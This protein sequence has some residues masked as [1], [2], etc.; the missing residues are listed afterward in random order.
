MWLAVGL[1][2]FSIAFQAPPGELQH[3]LLP[4]DVLHAQLVPVRDVVLAIASPSDRAA[5]VVQRQA[6]RVT[7]RVGRAGAGAADGDAG[8]A[9]HVGHDR[10]GGVLR[11]GLHGAGAVADL[12]DDARGDRRG[13]QRRRAAAAASAACGLRGGC[14]GLR[15]RS[16]GR[17]GG[18][19]PRPPRPRPWPAAAA[20][21]SAW[22]CD[23]A[24]AACS[25]SRSDRLAASWL[26]QLRLLHRPARRCRSR[27]CRG[28]RRRA[29]D[30]DARRS[31]WR[32]APRTARLTSGQRR[33]RS[34]R[35]GRQATR[36]RAGL[37]CRRPTTGRTRRRAVRVAGVAS[38]SVWTDS[39]S[40]CAVCRFRGATGGGSPFLPQPPTE[41]A[42]GFGPEV[43]LPARARA[44]FTPE[45]PWV[46]GLRTASAA[47]SSAVSGRGP[48]SRSG[49][50]R[51]GNESTTA[52][53]DTAEVDP[54]HI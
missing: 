16:S 53:R 21:S 29:T 49:A 32:P 24:A 30:G 41:L 2:R 22:A 23:A 48:R 10:V 3:P 31:R 26:E 14:G 13:R 51:T 36:V 54:C 50:R 9:G 45:E 25:A 42:D 7:A 15:G 40:G 52:S 28:R 12:R 33:R 18:L 17:G 4:D 34:R 19:R 8:G 1:P 11:D 38:S 20:A 35:R 27:R 43:A 37:R 44:G 6:R 47:R 39:S 5:H 46:P